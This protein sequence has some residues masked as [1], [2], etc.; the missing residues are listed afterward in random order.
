MKIYFILSLTLTLLTYFSVWFCLI[1]FGAKTI[2]PI[3][4]LISLAVI[5]A[6]SMI[7]TILFCIHLTKKIKNN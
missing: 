6:N 5:C 4:W 7:A 2:V 3:S 1:Y